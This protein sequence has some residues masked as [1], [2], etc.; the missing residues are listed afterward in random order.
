[1]GS[2]RVRHDRGDLAAAVDIVGF[3]FFS[4]KLKVCGNPAGSKS[5]SAIFLNSICS[6]HVSV[7]HC[8][9]SHN[10]SNLFVISMFVMVISDQ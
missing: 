6:V 2:H 8:G 3:F 10:T 9:N 5:I 1:M 4:P 7:A